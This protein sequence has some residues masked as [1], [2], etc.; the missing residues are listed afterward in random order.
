MSDVDW[1]K[2]GVAMRATVG[3]HGQGFVAARSVLPPGDLFPEAPFS[4]AA[5]KPAAASAIAEAALSPTMLILPTFAQSVRRLPMG[6]P[7]TFDRLVSAVGI[8]RILSSSL[9]SS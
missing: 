1:L 3:G 8:L 5:R 9:G 2:I 4:R 7:N 6:S